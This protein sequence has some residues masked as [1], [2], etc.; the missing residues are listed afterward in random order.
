MAACPSCGVTLDSPPNRRAECPHCG[1]PIAVR[2]GRLCSDEEAR[3]IDACAGLGIPLEYLW[4]ARERLSRECGY[5]ASAADAAWRLLNELAVN[6]PEY[7][8]RAMVYFGMARFLWKEG[9]DQLQIARQGR[10]MQLAEWKLVADEGLLDL[11]RAHI[12]I[13]TSREASC[14]ACRT[15]EGAQFTYQEA[16]EQNPIPAP[17]C[18]HEA[19]PGRARGWCSCSYGIRP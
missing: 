16:M 10:Q 11:K 14:P 2:E 4:S 1:R 18:T 19:G 5:Q 17:E 6:T 7:H 12:E 9:E 15:L 3:A 8:G 13:I